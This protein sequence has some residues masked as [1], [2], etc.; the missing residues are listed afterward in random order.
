VPAESA[1]TFGAKLIAVAGAAAAPG[2][3]ST[4]STNGDGNVPDHQRVGRLG[5]D[6]YNN[7]LAPSS[8]AFTR[9]ETV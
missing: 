4:G 9:A 5:V 6:V 2:D 3:G 7:E 8:G 1:K